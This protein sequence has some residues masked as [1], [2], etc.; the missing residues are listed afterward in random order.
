MVLACLL[1]LFMPMAQLQS[2]AVCLACLARAPAGK[3]L[4]RLPHLGSRLFYLIAA[5]PAARGHGSGSG[6]L[7][8]FPGLDGALFLL[9]PQPRNNA[10]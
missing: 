5:L 2:V 10:K 7:R 1:S 3:T 4:L 9:A 6:E 8:L